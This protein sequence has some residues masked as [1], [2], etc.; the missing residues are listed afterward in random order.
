MWSICGLIEG[1]HKSKNNK[2]NKVKRKIHGLIR[3]KKYS[4]ILPFPSPW[5]NYI[6]NG[7]SGVQSYKIGCVHFIK[8]LSEILSI[9]KNFGTNLLYF[10]FQMNIL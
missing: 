3:E 2:E 5:A 7:E 8:F 10:L 9:K 1:I 6:K 4:A